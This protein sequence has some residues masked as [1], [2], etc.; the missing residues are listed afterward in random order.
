MFHEE[1]EL[2]AITEQKLDDITG[3]VLEGDQFIG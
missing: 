2:A 3:E 1:I